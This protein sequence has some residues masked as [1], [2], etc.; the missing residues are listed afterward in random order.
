MGQCLAAQLTQAQSAQVQPPRPQ[1][2]FNAPLIQQTTTNAVG[3]CDVCQVKP[4]YFDGTKTHS[5]CSKTCAAKIQPASN[6]SPIQQTATNAISLCDV[7][8]VKPKYFDGTKTHACCS[9]TCAAKIRDKT[10]S[11]SNPLTRGK[12][13]MALRAAANMC[14]YCHKWP[15]YNDGQTTHSFCSKS[16]AQQA[17]AAGGV[18]VVP[19]KPLKNGCL[20]CGKAV[21][22]GHFCSQACTSNVE[23]N[24]PLL[25]EIPNAHDTF[26]SVA[27]QFKTSWRHATPCPTV[28]QIYKVIGHP[29][30]ISKYDAYRWVTIFPFTY[31][32]CLTQ[33]QQGV[34]R[35]SR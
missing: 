32:S 23:K 30:S 27:D 15:R 24:A 13:S 5:C 14:D 9:K 33:D 31:T 19:S 25:V 11:G 22:K 26:N 16:C 2:A 10:T 17:K 21:K 28:R 18:S 4:K 3:L 35:G 8:Q 34:C 20:L 12:S 1:P 6:I 7:C 29:T